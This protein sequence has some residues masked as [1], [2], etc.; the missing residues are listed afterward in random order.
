M[1]GVA[2]MDND[3]NQC[4]FRIHHVDDTSLSKNFEMVSCGPF[5]SGGSTGYIVLHTVGLFNET[6]DITS[7]SVHCSNT[8][9]QGTLKLWGVK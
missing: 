1:T 5:T 9:D 4:V 8:I 6:T 3:D 2:S 7:V